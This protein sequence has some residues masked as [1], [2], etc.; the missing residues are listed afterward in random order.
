MLPPLDRLRVDTV[1]DLAALEALSAEWNALAS[2]LS[3]RTPFTTPLWNILWWRHLSQSRMLVRDVLSAWAL[4]DGAGRLV[5][6]APMMRTRRP[7]RGPVGVR[8]LQFFGADPNLTEIRG[9]TC[10]PADEVRCMGQLLDHLRGR[11]RDWDWLHWG[12]IRDGHAAE[13][14][15]GFRLV[16]PVPDYWLPLPPDWPSFEAGLS[17]N[18]RKALRRSRA[19]LE[20]AGH[21]LRFQA[22]APDP[23]L[24]LPFE[25]FLALHA[26]RS[27][28]VD[29][30]AR[31][32]LF[33]SPRPRAFLRDYAGAMAGRGALRCFQLEIDGA[34]VAARLG[35]LLGDELYLSF[36]G[37]EPRW[38]PVGPMTL[39]TEAVACW[40]IEQGLRVLNLSTGSDFSKHRWGPAETQHWDGVLI[41]PGRRGR[42]AHRAYH[43]LLHRLQ[44]GSPAGRLLNIARR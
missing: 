13:S 21:R 38:A 11:A 19:A 16:R 36:S 6:V 34:V 10:R 40:A 30:P 4:R 1:P 17:R 2:A 44:A 35:F 7:A 32:D 29:L 25:R 41:A 31:P 43:G 26:A 20:R 42:T 28:A 24:G 33:A 3:P 15:H 9:L 23:G 22:V 8:I 39:L 14:R 37:F 18:L 12:G 27:R 5:G